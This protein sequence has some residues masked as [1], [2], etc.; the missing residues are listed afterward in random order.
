MAKSSK[1]SAP[2]VVGDD[3]LGWIDAGGGYQLSLDADKLVARNAKRRLAAVPRDVR[4]SAA[5]AQLEALRDW[6]AEHERDCAATVDQWMLRSRP[7][8]RAV[9]EQVWPDPAWRRPLENAV[10][11]AIRADGSLDPARAGLF[12]GVDAGRGVGV[13]DLDGETA[14][15]SSAQI[16]IP[17][18]ILLAELDGWRELITQIGA[19]QASAQLH[20]QTYARPA[21]AGAAITDFEHGKFAM[22]MHAVGKARAL[23]YKVRGGFAVCQVWDGPAAEARY[24][25]GAASPEA[26]TVTGALVWVDDRERSVPIAQLGPVAFS[27]GMRMAAAIYAARLAEREDVP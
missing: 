10:V 12:R 21:G 20:R 14:W 7:V 11:A 9:L 27:E 26:E 23:G 3:G 5:A 25:I 16:A 13:V 19:T 24:W 17:H 4:A 1:P 22:L 6:L 8:P 2:A 18:P 15:L